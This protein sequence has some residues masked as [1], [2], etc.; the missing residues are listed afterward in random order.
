ME[1]LNTLAADKLATPKALTAAEAAAVASHARNVA[2]ANKHP[3][4]RAQQKGAGVQ[5]YLD[6]M[7]A[8]T[9]NPV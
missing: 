2:S 7:L 4:S 8:C 5:G 3:P 6:S 9:T 1:P